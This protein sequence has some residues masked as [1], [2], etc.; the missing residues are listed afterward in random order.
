MQDYQLCHRLYDMGVEDESEVI[1]RDLW[2][3]DPLWQHLD[4][5]ETSQQMDDAQE[6]S[7]ERTETGHGY[8]FGV[9]LEFHS[10]AIQGDNILIKMIQNLVNKQMLILFILIGCIGD[11][12]ES[13]YSHR[14]PGQLI[15]TFKDSPASHI[16]QL[17][18]MTAN[19]S[20]NPSADFASLIHELG[21]AISSFGTQLAAIGAKYGNTSSIKTSTS[22]PKQVIR[23]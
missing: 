9:T 8:H 22:E 23:K 13:G 6:K 7:H 20:T 17:F 14:H 5:R 3:E 10:Q 16:H 1:W 21:Q 4:T 12:W 18:N 19:M 15:N 2:S 11:V